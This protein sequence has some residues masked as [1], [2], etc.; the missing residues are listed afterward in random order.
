MPPNPPLAASFL[1]LDAA[2]IF[3]FFFFSQIKKGSGQ[4]VS[5]WNTYSILF[6]GNVS[7]SVSNVLQFL[8]ILISYKDKSGYIGGLWRP[9]SQMRVSMG[10]TVRRKTAKNLA[11]RRKNERI[12]AV[13]R[14][15]N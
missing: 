9:V 10:L 7:Y 6:Q 5:P 14:K 13:S 4:S 3:F 2:T 12:L 11:V 8:A 1:Y 15:K